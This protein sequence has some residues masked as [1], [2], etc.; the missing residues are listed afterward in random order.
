MNCTKHN[1]YTNY[2][3]LGEMFV[4]GCTVV[5]IYTNLKNMV[6][7]KTM[8]IYKYIQSLTVFNLFTHKY[9]IFLEVF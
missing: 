9:N 3:I 5:V 4:I 6:K 1:I 7:L 2:F 8:N